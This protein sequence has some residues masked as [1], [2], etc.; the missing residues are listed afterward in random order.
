M[1]IACARLGGRLAKLQL[2]CADFW[3]EEGG[4]GANEIGT[5][6]GCRAAFGNGP[7]KRRAILHYRRA[8][9]SRENPSRRR[10]GVRKPACHR[11][12]APA[13]AEYFAASGASRGLLR[14]REIRPK[15]L[16]YFGQRPAR[17]R[18]RD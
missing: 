8:A 9:G 17:S 12:R 13:E 10:R 14:P 11:G 18:D 5:F 15:R 6:S 3:N 4:G 7:R 2:R 16:R 1:G